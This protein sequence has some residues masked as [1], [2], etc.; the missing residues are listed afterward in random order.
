MRSKG[1]DSIDRT[2]DLRISGSIESDPFDL[3]RLRWQCRRGMRELDLLLLQFLDTGYADLDA[4]GA[5]AFLRLLDSPDAVLLEWLLGR[6]RPSDK[7]VADVV[8]RIRGAAAT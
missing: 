7:E 4:T 3:N 1:S 2:F 6:Q 8:Q 5:Q